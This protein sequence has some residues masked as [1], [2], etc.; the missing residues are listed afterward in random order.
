MRLAHSCKAISPA[1]P[2]HSMCVKIT[3]ATWQH[4]IPLKVDVKTAINWVQNL[5]A[6][7]PQCD[8]TMFPELAP[9]RLDFEIAVGLKAQSG[10]EGGEE[11]VGGGGG[12]GTIGSML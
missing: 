9:K 1:R 10:F 4:V 8:W 3:E 11:G 2:N 5:L 6:T 12:G 7:G